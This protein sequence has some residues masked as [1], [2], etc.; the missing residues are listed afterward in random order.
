M[1]KLC[2]ECGVNERAHHRTKC[3]DCFNKWRRENTSGVE[4]AKKYREKNRDKVNKKRKELHYRQK[5]G[6]WRV[7]TLPNANYYVGYTGI[8]IERRMDRH[9]Y[10]GNNTDDYMI[11]H[12]CDSEEEALWYESVYHE[13]GFPGKYGYK[14]THSN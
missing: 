8:K 2:N 7:Y 4:H 12:V 9:R 11:L 14:K 6:K 3:R 10:V 5:D 13:I 1:N